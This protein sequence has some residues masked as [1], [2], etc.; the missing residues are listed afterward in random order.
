MACSCAEVS[1][2]SPRSALPKAER[3]EKELT[4]QQVEAI[5]EALG[6]A[7]ETLTADAPQAQTVTDEELLDL[8]KSADPEA[9]NAAVSVLKGEQPQGGDMMSMFAGMMGGAGAA[10]ADQGNAESSE[11]APA[12]EEAAKEE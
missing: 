5:A 9:K 2:A 3:G 11:N 12:E 10:G 6:V 4:L 1:S 7:P 8:L